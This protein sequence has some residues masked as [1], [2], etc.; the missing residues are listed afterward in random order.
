MTEPA[1]TAAP[2]G[3]LGDFVVAWGPETGAWLRGLSTFETVSAPGDAGQ[4]AVRG[5]VA[6]VARP[7]ADTG[8]GSPI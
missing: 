3:V 1:P 2:S 8:S 6:A 5:A 7:T 4:A